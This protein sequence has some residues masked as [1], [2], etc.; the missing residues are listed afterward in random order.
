MRLK[1]SQGLAVGFSVFAA[2]DCG[3]SGGETGGSGGTGGA[4][5]TSRGSSASQTGTSTSSRSGSSNSSSRSSSSSSRSTSSASSAVVKYCSGGAAQSSDIVVDV[6]THYQTIRGF[7]ACSAWNGTLSD[8]VGERLF[9]TTKGAGLSLHRVQIQGNGQVDSA[10][11]ANAK[12]ASKY[13]VKVWGTPWFSDFSTQHFYVDQDHSDANYMEEKN[14]QKWADALAVGAG[15]MTQA[16]VPLYAISAE[17]EP[18]MGWIYYTPQTMATWVAKYLGPTLANKSPDTKIMAPE[19]SNGCGFG[20]YE[21][22]IEADADAWKY[23]SILATHAYGCGVDS[24]PKIQAAGKEYW[25]TEISVC[26][27]NGDCDASPS[28]M[29]TGIPLAK[30][31]TD[32][33]THGVSA[34]HYWN[35]FGTGSGALI[36]KSVKKPDGSFTDYPAEGGPTKLP[37]VMGNWARF[38]RPG[39]VRVDTSGTMPNGVL[40]TAFLDP[41]NNSLAIVA[42]NDNKSAT[43]VSFYISDKAPCSLTAYETSAN[44]DLGQGPSISVAG[45][46]V[47]ATL[48]A[49]S[50]TTFA[51]TPTAQ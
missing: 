8:S 13:G 28:D 39:F 4:A 5:S 50:V 9:S 18:D 10:E 25:E 21:P 24:Y 32:H 1:Y 41:S 34:W 37:W 38:V 29:S 33:L 19:T 46:R 14:M 49:Q 20:G 51:G 35:V 23:T 36:P 44:E 27:V 48:A 12:L 31:M 2:V 17:N 22:A 11:M 6:K 26:T 3:G 43:N 42:I 47:T 40:V 16:G 30:M 7:G 15:L 45:S